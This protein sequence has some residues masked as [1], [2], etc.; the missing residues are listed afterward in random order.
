M[1]PKTNRLKKKKDFDFIFKKGKGFK[2]ALFVVK[3]AENK[4]GAPRFGFIIS[5]KISKKA[6]DR[7]KIRRRASEAIRLSLQN[8]KQG[9]DVVFIALK[10]AKTAT[11]GEI[12]ESIVQLLKKGGLLKT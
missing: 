12:E 1:L 8:I 3:M 2:S 10:A 11:K 6:V 5:S 9:Y 7:N 4:L